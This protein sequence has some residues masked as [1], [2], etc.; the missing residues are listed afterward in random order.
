MGQAH[1]PLC[2]FGEGVG[3]KKEAHRESEW[4]LGR[5]AALQSWERL[6]RV[7]RTQML[8]SWRERGLGEDPCPEP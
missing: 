5:S 6:G 7:D 8:T 1:V 2:T 3:T 4:T